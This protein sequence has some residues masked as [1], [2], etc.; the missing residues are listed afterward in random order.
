[1]HVCDDSVV[2]ARQRLKILMW[3]QWFETKPRDSLQRWRSRSI[4]FD[5]SPSQA[6]ATMTPLWAHC[7]LPSVCYHLPS[8][9]IM[10]V[11]KVPSTSL[12]AQVSTSPTSEGAFSAW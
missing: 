6:G 8:S 12:S 9:A 1:M 7:L 4:C 2:A 11:S 10:V 3:Y 5:V